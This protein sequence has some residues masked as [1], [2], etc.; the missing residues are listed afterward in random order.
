MNCTRLSDMSE[1]LITLE[2]KVRLGSLVPESWL[3]GGCLRH[4]QGEA[5]EPQP[6]GAQQA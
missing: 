5:G 6:Q 1:R 2:A 4:L 3:W